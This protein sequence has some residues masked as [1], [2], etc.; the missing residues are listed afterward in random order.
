MGRVGHHKVITQAG[1]SFTRTQ[2][3]AYALIS[4]GLVVLNDLPP[5]QINRFGVI[6]KGH[7]IQESGGSLL[8]CHFLKVEVSTMVSIPLSAPCLTR[9]W[10]T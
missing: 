4:A 1:L 5:L 6:P 2:L 3:T 9:Q 7:I 8:T 10:M